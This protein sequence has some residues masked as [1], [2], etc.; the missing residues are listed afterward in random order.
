[1]VL[2][3]RVESGYLALEGDEIQRVL[4]GMTVALIR[5]NSL[6]LASFATSEHFVYLVSEQVDP[7]A[8]LQLVDRVLPSLQAALHHQDTEKY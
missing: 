7:E 3:E 8:V 2:E 4:Q 5:P 6:I 1:V